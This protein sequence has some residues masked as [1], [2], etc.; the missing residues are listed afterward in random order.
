M[1]SPNKIST[2]RT[3]FPWT[4]YSR[5]APPFWNPQEE[6]HN[7]PPWRLTPPLDFMISTINHL[8][9]SPPSN[10]C[11][12]IFTQVLYEHVIKVE[13]SYPVVFIH[14]NTTVDEHL[15]NISVSLTAGQGQCTFPPFGQ[16]VW[17]STLQW[18]MI[19]KDNQRVNKKGMLSYLNYTPKFNCPYILEQKLDDSDLSMCS[20]PHQGGE[21]FLILEIDHSF[22]KNDI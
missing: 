21:A 8:T 17:I 5:G 4:A 14:I 6:H 10:V 13:Y 12:C 20:C 16:E 2:Q 9:E 1:S 22:F 11:R 7:R 15:H 18:W 3:W 19:Q